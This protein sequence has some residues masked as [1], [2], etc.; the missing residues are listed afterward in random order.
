MIRSSISGMI[1]GDGWLRLRQRQRVWWPE[2]GGEDLQRLRKF[3]GGFPA[4]SATASGGTV[5]VTT[6][7]AATAVGDRGSDLTLKGF[8]GRKKERKARSEVVLFRH[9]NPGEIKRRKAL[10]YIF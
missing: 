1:S 3:P 10:Y 5:A 2:T 9:S 7:A 8:E 4:V 6:K